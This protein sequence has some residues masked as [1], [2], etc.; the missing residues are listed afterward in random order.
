[1]VIPLGNSR[2]LAHIKSK[3]WGMN[4]SLIEEMVNT[5][6]EQYAKYDAGTLERVW[7]SLLQAYNQTLLSLGEKDF[8]VD[9]T[10]L[11]VNYAA[12]SGNVGAGRKIR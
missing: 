4:A 1:M 6:F 5:I 10:P 7:Q 3:V 12:D 2:A 9:C 8:T 11:Q